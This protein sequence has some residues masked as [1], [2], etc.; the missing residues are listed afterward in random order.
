MWHLKTKLGTFWVVEA[1]NDLKDRY[2]LGVND[3]ELGSYNDL[4]LAAKDVHEQA[5]GYLQ[6]DSQ[7]KVKA[8]DN[9]SQWVQG[10]PDNWAQ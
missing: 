2:F 4:D 10:V 6:W 9:I 8:P 5:T 3:Q 7:A 1:N